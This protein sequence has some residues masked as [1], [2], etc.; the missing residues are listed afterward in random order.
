MALTH[1]H[2]QLPAA[3]PLCAGAGSLPVWSRW[4]KSLAGILIALG[5]IRA[6]DAW[7]AFAL[8]G[9]TQDI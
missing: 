7:M 6:T 3:K 4:P 8:F 2:T 1:G 9:P 5:I